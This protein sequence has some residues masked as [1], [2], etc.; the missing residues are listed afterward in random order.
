MFSLCARLLPNRA[1]PASAVLGGLVPFQAERHLHKKT[2]LGGGG[3]NKPRKSP[4]K[5]GVHELRLGVVRASDVFYPGRQATLTLTDIRE[6]KLLY[7]A[8]EK[9]GGMF[10]AAAWQQ[11]AGGDGPQSWAGYGVGCLLKISELLHKKPEGEGVGTIYCIAQPYARVRLH[12]PQLD[13]FGYWTAAVSMFAD[14]VEAAQARQEAQSAGLAA[15]EE[16]CNRKVAGIIELLHTRRYG[17]TYVGSQ[18]QAQKVEQ[19]LRSLNHWKASAVRPE[20]GNPRT[21]MGDGSE[22]SDEPHARFA[23][24]SNFTY[25]LSMVVSETYS[26][27]MGAKQALLECASPGARLDMIHDLLLAQGSS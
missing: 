19:V 2:G 1:V 5:A 15:Q 17:S 16:A 24:L 25:R 13:P 10:T 7:D 6:W 11:Q 12:T 9:H 22:L 23:R 4:P 26:M 18:V 3:K 20:F 21:S 8:D 14:Q 27:D